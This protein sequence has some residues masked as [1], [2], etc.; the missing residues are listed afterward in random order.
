MNTMFSGGASPMFVCFV[1]LLFSGLFRPRARSALGTAKIP[2]LHQP[3]PD[4]SPDR[5]VASSISLS[6]IELALLAELSLE[7]A[8]EHETLARDPNQR[9]ETRQTA[10]KAAAAWRERARILQLEAG[11][12]SWAPMLPGR[13]TEVMASTYAGPERRRHIRR[14]QTRRDGPQAASGSTGSRERRTGPD[15]RRSD[16]RRPQLALR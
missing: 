8:R 11:R 3:L 6:S 15:R 9:L 13:P 16:R 1:L 12:Q 10:S 14:A 7:Q 4:N 2:S 5:V